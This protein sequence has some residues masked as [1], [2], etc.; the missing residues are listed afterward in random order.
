MFKSKC[1]TNNREKGNLYHFFNN[2]YFKKKDN[3]N[4]YQLFYIIILMIKNYLNKLLFTTCE[5]LKYKRKIN[6]LNVKIS[7]FQ[8]S[9]CKK[10]QSTKR[11]NF[12]IK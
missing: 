1:M 10:L 12:I 3:A 2:T 8:Y 7:L 9:N 4:A 5:L 6:I 11:N